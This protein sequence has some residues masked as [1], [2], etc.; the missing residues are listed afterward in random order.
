MII[1]DGFDKWLDFATFFLTGLRHAT[2][3]LRRVTL[4][5]GNKRMG[6]WV[7]FGAGVERLNNDDLKITPLVSVFVFL[8]PMGP[9]HALEMG[10]GRLT[11]FPAYLPRVMIATRPTLRTR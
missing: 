10:K 9:S 11:F 6:K 3:D 8:L 2:S 7:R 1:I 4:N 5:S